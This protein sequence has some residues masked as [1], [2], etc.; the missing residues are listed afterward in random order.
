M[1]EITATKTGSTGSTGEYIRFKAEKIIIDIESEIC[2][3][4]GKKQ[5]M[6]ANDEVIAEK[7]RNLSR[8]LP[9]NSY[10]SLINATRETA[11]ANFLDNIVNPST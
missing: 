11:L 7:K 4:E 2:T 1:A 3:L 10:S 6:N 5:Y 8:K 9:S